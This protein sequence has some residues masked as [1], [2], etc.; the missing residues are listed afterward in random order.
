MAVVKLRSMQDTRIKASAATARRSGSWMFLTATSIYWA[1]NLKK[2]QIRKHPSWMQVHGAHEHSD[3]NS[4]RKHPWHC[5]WRSK[6]IEFNCVPA[7]VARGSSAWTE[8]VVPANAENIFDFYTWRKRRNQELPL[9]LPW[10]QRIGLQ[11]PDKIHGPPAFTRRSSCGGR[12]TWNCDIYFWKKDKQGKDVKIKGR[13]TVILT[14]FPP[15]S[16]DTA[17]VMFA[18]RWLGSHPQFDGIDKVMQCDPRLEMRWQAWPS[19][20]TSSMPGA[21]QMMRSW[22]WG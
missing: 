3:F 17:D 13:H 19:L 6:W 5:L 7:T 11:N 10:M 15:K 16:K 18:K 2:G 9:L 12:I 22:A 21:A 1:I 8:V 14:K 4:R 20:L